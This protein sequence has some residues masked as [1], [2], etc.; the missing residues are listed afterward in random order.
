M[1]RV[2]LQITELSGPHSAHSSG[3]KETASQTD[4]SDQVS[5]L[6]DFDLGPFSDETFV[7]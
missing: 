4:L 1:N 2:I 5:A 6:T 3:S 7:I